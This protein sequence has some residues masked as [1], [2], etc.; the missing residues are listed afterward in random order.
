MSQSDQISVSLEKI[1]TPLHSSFH[2]GVYKQPYFSGAWHYHPEI[3]LLSIT[4]G[5]GKRLVG[6]HVDQ[7]EPDDLVLLGGL[8]PHAWIP[9]ES[10]LKEDSE[11]FCESIY[12]QFNKEIFGSFFVSVPELKGVRKALGYSERGLKITGKHKKEINLLLREI[13]KLNPFD[14]LIQLLKI[15]NLISLSDYELLVSE[16]YLKKSFYFKS[17]RMLKIHEYLMENYKQEIHIETCAEIANMTISSFC[18][19]FK[20]ETNTTF[21][22]YLNAIRIDVAKKLLANTDYAIKEIGF[23]CGYNS[24]PYFNKQFKKIVGYTPFQYRKNQFDTM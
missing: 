6:D 15:L 24:T 20:N 2:T 19:F 5:F 14:Q 8:L 11:K 18:R 10:F 3:E 17:N 23:E 7:F 1:E 9:D 12:V 22:N 13:P 21:S 4:K 16:N